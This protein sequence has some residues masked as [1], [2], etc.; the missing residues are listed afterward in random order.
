MMRDTLAGTTIF[1]HD[2]TRSLRQR[3]ADRLHCGP[4]RWTVPAVTPRAKGRGFYFASRA[5]LA[6]GS[7][8]GLRIEQ[9]SCDRVRG[10]FADDE[11][12]MIV[13]PY[14]IRLPHRRGFLA[15]AGE[16]QGMWGSV[17]YDVYDDQRDADR[18]AHQL[19]EHLAQTNR[20]DHAR[21]L[22]LLDQEQAATRSIDAIAV[23]A[24]AWLA[25]VELIVELSARNEASG[26][27]QAELWQD[28][29]TGF[30]FDQLGDF[31]RPL[32]RPA[33]KR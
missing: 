5:A 26:G 33:L 7:F 19:A 3:L 18:A 11:G 8:A 15:A 13:R 25:S 32:A 9:A 14:V 2:F 1:L 30:A 27:L 28:A 29:V 6:M 31:L 22:A 4:Y 21:A 20:D 12:E 23:D 24:A 10:Y 17:E 16:G